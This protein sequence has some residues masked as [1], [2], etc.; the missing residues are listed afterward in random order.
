V[1]PEA[2]PLTIPLFPAKI[3]YHFNNKENV[4]TALLPIEPIIHAAE[5]NELVIETYIG[6]GDPPSIDTALVVADE[7]INMLIKKITKSMFVPE[8]KMAIAE[9]LVALGIVA[10][11]RTD[12]IIHTL[13]NVREI[14]AEM[15]VEKLCEMRLAFAASKHDEIGWIRNLNNEFP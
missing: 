14:D 12:D 1:Y 2:E 9:H 11:G 6:Y 10:I 13:T 15:L 5:E 3:R 7:T 4:V 8:E